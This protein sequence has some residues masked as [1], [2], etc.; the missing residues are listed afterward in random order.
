VTAASARRQ[1]DQAVRNAVYR[2][3]EYMAAEE[4]GRG[5]E[6]RE[7]L[8]IGLE[9]AFAEYDLAPDQVD[10]PFIRDAWKRDVCSAK[11]QGHNGRT[12]TCNRPAAEHDE[13]ELCVDGEDH[14]LNRGD[15]MRAAQE[16]RR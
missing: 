16:E 6:M 8:R 9:N 4:L 10:H 2:A 14:E 15:H 1:R 5:P 13:P 7:L 11:V 3:K 12:E